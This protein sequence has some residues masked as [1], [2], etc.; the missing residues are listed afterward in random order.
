MRAWWRE[1]HDI[2]KVTTGTIQNYVTQISPAPT[3]LLRHRTHRVQPR[4]GRTD[5][6][7]HPMIFLTHHCEAPP[8]TVGKEAR[9]CPCGRY[10]RTSRARTPRYRSPGG[11]CN[12]LCSRRRLEAVVSAKRVREAE[13]INRTLSGFSPRTK[14]VRRNFE[15]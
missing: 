13:A 8:D 15:S 11:G 9:A 5:R 10:G 4:R 3:Y 2:M 14:S 12:L 6:A 1:A 7:H